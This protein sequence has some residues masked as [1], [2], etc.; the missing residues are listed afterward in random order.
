MEGN[1]GDPAVMIQPA[2]G[3]SGHCRIPL[4]GDQ[5]FC[6]RIDSEKE[7]LQRDGAQQ[8][9]PVGRDEAR[10][11]RL[12]PFDGDRDVGD[13]PL[14]LAAPGEHNELRPSW[15]QVESSGDRRRNHDQC[16]A[17][18]DEEVGDDRL[19]RTPCELY[20]HLELPHVDCECTVS[21]APVVMSKKRYRARGATE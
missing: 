18:V 21:G 15:R 20:R 1:A 12:S 14:L 11:R 3:A 9:R 6:H 8:C 10:S 17:G 4:H 19:T 5:P 2:A 13:R 16:R 7:A